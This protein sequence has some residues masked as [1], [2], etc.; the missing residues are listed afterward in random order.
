MWGLKCHISNKLLSDADTA[1]S[2]PHVL[3][4]NHVDPEEEGAGLVGLHHLKEGGA[5]NGNFQH[6][7]VK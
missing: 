5:S 6:L 2:G 1:G 4:S 3:R 7:S